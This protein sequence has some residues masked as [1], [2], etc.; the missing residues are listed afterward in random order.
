MKYST[1]SR[2]TINGKNGTVVVAYE[3]GGAAMFKYDDSDS[4]FEVKDQTIKPIKV[5]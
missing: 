1:G 5:D 4:I 3:N 2:I